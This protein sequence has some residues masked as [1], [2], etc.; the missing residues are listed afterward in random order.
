V[1]LAGDIMTGLVNIFGAKPHR[2][3]K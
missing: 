3:F 2:D 1:K